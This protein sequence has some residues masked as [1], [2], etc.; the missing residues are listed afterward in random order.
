MGVVDFYVVFA[1]IMGFVVVVVV[2][3]LL[4]LLL[5]CCYYYFSQNWAS[6]S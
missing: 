4:I 6:F 3:V 2:I 5:L 1:D